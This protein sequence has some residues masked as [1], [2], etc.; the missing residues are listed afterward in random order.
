MNIVGLITEYNPFHKGHEYHIHRAKELTNADACVVIMSGNYV[1]RG[2][3][4]F[5]NK[6][7]RAAIALNHGADIIFELPL[8]F[9]CSS[10]E[11]FATAAVTLLHKMGCINYICFGCECDDISALTSIAK[12]LANAKHDNTHK[13][14]TLIKENLKT[15]LPY[16]TARGNALA[17]ILGESYSHIVDKP[18]N[19]LAIEYLKTLTLLNS[20]IQPVAIPRTNAAY[21][22][23]D[24][25]DA[26]YSASSLRSVIT[27]LNTENQDI[28]DELITFDVTYTDILG[29]TAPINEDDFSSLLG[30]KL[31]SLSLQPDGIEKLTTY[32]GID[33]VL[34]N[35]MLSKEILY[36]YKSFSDLIGKLKKKNIAYTSLSRALLALTL[37]ITK[38][39]M[40]DYLSNSISSYVKLLGFK[41]N[42]SFVLN[43]IKNKGNLTIIGQLSEVKNNLSLTDIDHRMLSHNLYC[44]EIYNMVIRQKYKT[45]IPSEYTRKLKIV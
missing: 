29:H 3:P 16:A 8:P 42:A 4:A 1:Q 9:A 18:N 38:D 30:D 36:R 33:T 22:H 2:T 37:G 41:K 44:D 31:L 34:A 13:L 21:H 5:V 45:D 15:G 43:E 11:Y 25:N 17:T 14:N 19:I 27:N 12:V 7:T 20:P 24:D 28:L 23:H 10:A 32:A 40:N 6:H 39:N 26:L 35:R